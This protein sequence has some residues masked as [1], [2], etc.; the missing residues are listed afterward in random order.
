MGR[1]RLV[2]PLTKLRQIKA[3]GLSIGA[4]PIGNGLD[5]IFRGCCRSIEATD[6]GGHA[7]HEPGFTQKCVQHAN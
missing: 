3:K 5:K 2:I 1:T 6:I 7:T 4:G